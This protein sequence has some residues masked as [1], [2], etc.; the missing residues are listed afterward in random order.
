MVRVRDCF[1]RRLLRM[2]EPVQAFFDHMRLH[3][4]GLQGNPAPR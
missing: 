1:I 2:A 3:Q 4:R